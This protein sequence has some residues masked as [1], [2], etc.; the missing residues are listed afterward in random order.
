M[1]IDASFK[2]HISF[3]NYD[4]IFQLYPLLQHHV[5]IAFR[6]THQSFKFILKNLAI[7]FN[8]FKNFSAICLQQPDSFRI[9][10]VI[11]LS[12]VFFDKV[13]LLL[14]FFIDYLG[15]PTDIGW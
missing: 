8:R 12:I 4:K 1:L 14:D 6:I 13:N 2:K 11:I 15:S 9:V 5:G 10:H 7:L 3:G